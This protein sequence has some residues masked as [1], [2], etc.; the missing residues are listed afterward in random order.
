[1]IALDFDGAVFYRPSGS[2][3]AL[4]L[5]G[6]VP[7]SL[8]VQRHPQNDGYRLPSPPTGFP[9][10]PHDPVA[11]AETA[12]SAAGTCGCR[13]SAARADAAQFRRIDED[14]IPRIVLFHR[15]PPNL[16]LKPPVR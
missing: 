15:N 6:Q 11:R 16:R 1:M 4:Q 14:G 9:A 10:D 3:S 8:F 5:A 12:F 13:L 7:Y 2:A